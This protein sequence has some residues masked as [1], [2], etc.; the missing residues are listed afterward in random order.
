M[1]IR[2]KWKYFAFLFFSI[3]CRG[4]EEEARVQF[5]QENLK[6]KESEKPKKETPDY[7]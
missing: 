6:K 5:I 3:Q 4:G 2:I 1:K 7:S